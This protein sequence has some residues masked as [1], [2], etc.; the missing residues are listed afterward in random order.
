MAYKNKTAAEYHREWWQK[1]KEKNYEVKKQW[2][3]NNPERWRASSLLTAYRQSDRKNNR[4]ECTLTIDWIIDNIFS[5]PCAHCGKEGWDVIGC[6]RLD[7]SKPHTED[8][9]EPCCWECNQKLMGKEL[10]RDN[11]GRFLKNEK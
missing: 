6:N 7:N 1:R 8:N 11:K 3:K 4:G 9:V 2:I 10:K 5:K